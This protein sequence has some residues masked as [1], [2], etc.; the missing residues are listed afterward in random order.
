MYIVCRGEVAVL[1]EGGR[2]VARTGEGGYFGEM[3][4]L[5]GEPRSATV[6][7]RGDCT[8][9]EIGADAFKAYVT[10]HPEVIEALAEVAAGRRRQLDESRAAAMSANDAHISLVARMRRFFGLP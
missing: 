8:L 1:V 3:S 9:L 6:V 2:E 7:A 5:T 4:L 10:T